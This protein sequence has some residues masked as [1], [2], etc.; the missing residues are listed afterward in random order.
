MLELDCAP[1]SVGSVDPEGPRFSAW[2]GGVRRR[3]ADVFWKCGVS[4]SRL[5]WLYDEH[6]LG[7]GSTAQPES[8]AHPLL[9]GDRGPL[10]VGARSTLALHSFQGPAFLGLFGPGVRVCL[11]DLNPFP[12]VLSS[13]HHCTYERAEVRGLHVPPTSV[14]VC[15]DEP[16]S[17][18][19]SCLWRMQCSPQQ[20]V[21]PMYHS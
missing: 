13:R 18:W 12:P 15:R 16:Q 20:P 14:R 17:E 9:E 4:W 2:C 1:L 6:A 8:A 7:M 11:S 5:S 10:C 21:T 19:V 3:E